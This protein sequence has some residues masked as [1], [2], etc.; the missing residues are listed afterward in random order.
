M[1]LM[2]LAKQLGA[3]LEGDG[4]KAVTSVASLREAGPE[5]ISFLADARHVERVR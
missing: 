3:R 4:Q 5:N 2:D 1:K